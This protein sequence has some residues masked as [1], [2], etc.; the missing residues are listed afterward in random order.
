MHTTP[1]RTNTFVFEPIGGENSTPCL[2][3]V[4][5]DGSRSLARLEDLAAANDQAR[6]LFRADFV[7]H[8]ETQIE[9]IRKP[10]PPVHSQLD[11]PIDEHCQKCD[12]QNDIWSWNAAL[13]KVLE[14]VKP[15]P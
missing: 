12:D 8:L 10:E 9:L 5:T 3:V 11:C 15:K 13:D 14:I 4:C 7:A 1:Q 6:L 2:F